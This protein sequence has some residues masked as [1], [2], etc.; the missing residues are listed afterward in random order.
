[1]EVFQDFHMVFLYDDFHH[2]ISI[3]GPM[4]SH[5]QRSI[6]SLSCSTTI[7]EVF[8]NNNCSR[9]WSG[10]FFISLFETVP[11]Q[12]MVGCPNEYGD[13]SPQKNL[14]LRPSQIIQTYI[15]QKK[16][17]RSISLVTS[18]CDTLLFIEL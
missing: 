12:N 6:M 8:N 14:G 9:E 15:H 13:T 3:L 18:V 17:S 1:M 5:N 7:T 10:F 11:A 16:F 4:S 2:H